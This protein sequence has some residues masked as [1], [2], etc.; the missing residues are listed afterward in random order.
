MALRVLNELIKI[1]NEKTDRVDVIRKLLS[2]TI[3]N[4]K[5]SFSNNE[6]F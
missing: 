5:I 3:E 1:I 4:D 2:N 6:K